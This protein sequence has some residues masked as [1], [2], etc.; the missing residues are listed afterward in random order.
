[1]ESEKEELMSRIKKEEENIEMVLLQ[2][3]DKNT[4]CIQK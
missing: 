2:L 1:M 3:E 4:E